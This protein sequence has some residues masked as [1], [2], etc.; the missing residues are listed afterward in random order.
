MTRQS[1]TNSFSS[2]QQRE[3]AL[4]AALAAQKA[5]VLALNAERDG[6]SVLAR[7]VE[8]AQKLYDQALQRYG[9][10][11][12]EG[13][14]GQTEVAVLSSAVIPSSPA[15]PRIAL[16]LALAVFLGALLGIG[17]A[18]LREM[19][20]RRVRSAYDLIAVLGAPV[21]GVLVGDAD[22]S[23][24]LPRNNWLSLPAARAA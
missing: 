3:G 18:L 9:Q 6:G 24:R 20:D 8:G 12:L 1:L 13:H 10:T 19:T 5:K 16:N 15:S 21:L 11:R 7:E 14:A 2:A 17:L 4:R 22:T 23:R